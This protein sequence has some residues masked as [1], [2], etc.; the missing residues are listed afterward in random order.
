MQSGDFPRRSC[1]VPPCRSR[2]AQCVER[3][4]EPMLYDR[5][6]DGREQT[7]AMRP[8]NIR[9]RGCCRGCGIESPAK[10]LAGV[11]EPDLDAIMSQHFVVECADQRELLVE[12]GRRA[13]LSGREILRELT[14]KPWPALCATADH[15]GIST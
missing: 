1:R 4:A 14:G 8:D 3:F 13:A 5:R 9:G 12:R 2:G 6:F 15:H 11:A 10:M 7:A